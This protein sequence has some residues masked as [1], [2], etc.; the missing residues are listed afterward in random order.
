MKH[1]SSTILAK[2]LQ[3]RQ[4]IVAPQFFEGKH[5]VQEDFIAH[6]ARFKAMIATRRF[7][8]SYTGGLYLCK[9]A[10][11]NPG[12]SCIYI[13]LTRESARK[14]MFKDILKPINRKLK[15]QMKFN[16]TALSATLPNGSV[17]Y[18]M[19]VDSSE[20]E[21]D[22]LLGQKYKVAI[23]DECASFSIDLRE[24]V[25]GTLKPAMADLGGTIAMLGTPGNLT[26][27]LFFDVT[28]G[29]EP[30]WHVIKADTK[31]NPYMAEKWAKEI[32][33]LK[34]NQPYITETPMFKQMYLG[35]WVIDTDSLVY[36]FNE[37][38]NLFEHLPMYARGDWQYMLGVD[39]GYD[40]DSAFVV[41]AWHEHD[42]SLYVVDVFKRSK[43][44]ITDVATQIKKMQSRYGIH[45][46]VIDGANKQAVEEIQKRHQI[47]LI[48]ADKT[49]KSDF[50]EIMNSEL[51]QGHIKLHT[52]LARPLIEEWSGL[53]WKESAKKREEHPNCPNHLS[54]A[55]LYIWR[56]CYSYLSEKPK[57]VAKW[58]TTEWYTEEEE[59]MEQ[60]A[61][62]HFKNIENM[63]N[64]DF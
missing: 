21:K 27:S 47:P 61:M 9:E 49:G 2:E 41:T 45:K 33:E 28:S 29:K 32:E 6:P 64:D 60:E 50:I 10:Y 35:Q 1:I 8:K 51:I 39:L 58:G 17:I 5:I 59:R 44:D 19:G 16:E 22:K 25:Y 3:K 30:G 23:I 18:C 40:D 54:D 34:K 14:I 46:I 24:L 4:H 15:L 52:A 13:A 7:G 36:K 12:V 48:T 56:Y 11:E 53:V 37:E 20:D 63:Q 62:E 57:E 38:R 42:K 43:M 26:K 31:D 55:C